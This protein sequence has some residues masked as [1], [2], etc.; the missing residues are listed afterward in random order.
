MYKPDREITSFTTPRGLYCYKVMPFG[1]KNAGATFQRMVTKM[2][3]PMLG[4]TMEAYI[5]DMVVKSREKSQHL[6]DLAEMFAILKHYKLRLNASK[7]VFGVGT[8]KFLGFLVTNP[9]IEADPSQIKAIQELERPNSTRD[10]QHLAGMATALSR[11]ISRSSDRCRPFCKTLKS[12]FFWDDECDRALADLKAYLSSAPILVTS[13][14]GEELY[15]YLAISQHAVSPVLVRAEGIQHLP[16][17]Y[18]SKTLLPA[19]TRYLPLEKLALALMMASR[20]LAH[21]FHAHTIVVL[22][23]FPLKVL[24]EKADF[25]GRILKWAVELGQYDIKFRPRA[26]I[27]AQ[28]LADFVAEFAPGMHPVCPIDL[29]DADL[30]QPMVLAMKTS[31]GSQVGKGTSTT[32]LTKSGDDEP[33]QDKGR[34]QNEPIKDLELRSSQNPS[35][36]WK[37]FMGEMW[38]L[39]VDGASNRHG[40]GLGIVLNSPDGLVI[41]QAITLGFPA[42]NNEAEY[43]ALL[44]GLRNALRMKASALMVFSDSKLVVNQVSGEYEARDERM[45]K[46]QALVCAKIKKFDAI[47]VE[48]INREGNNTADELAG[49]ASTQT[50]FPNPLMIEFLPRLSIEEPEVAEVLC[51]DL[52]PSWMDP[53]I[54]FLKDRILPEEKKVEAFLYEIHEGICGSHTRGRSL[55]YRAISQGYWWLCM[56]ADAQKYVRRCEKCQKFAHQ[57]HQPARDLLP[58]S[59]PWSFALWGLDIVGPLPAT[60]G[61]RKFFI[62]ATDYFTKWVEAEPLAT[63]KEKDVKKFVWQN[64]IT[65]FG[66]PKALIPDNGTQ[67]DGKLFREFCEEL[68]TEFYNLTSAYPQSNGQLF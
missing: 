34:D 13:Q 2:F 16:I 38:K 57:I 28:A 54:A 51:T 46:Y 52:G 26:A 37:L 47:R 18:V 39:F 21:Y 8:G 65:H 14:P 20:K 11:F 41:E 66:I 68:K 17:F 40:A 67:F 62:S 61:N 6:A 60:P 64:V 22:T 23:E 4:R 10:V 19:E 12:K 35:D 15:L 42:S 24:F 30:A 50:V 25:A 27:K 36:C 48:Q 32:E 58:L 59:S 55:A 33:N 56:Q 31:V 7:C 53:I 49:L 3:T 44:A 29:V 1:L 63:I 5:D 9:G 45:A 43:E